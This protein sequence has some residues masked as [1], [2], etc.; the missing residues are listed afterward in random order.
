MIFQAVSSTLGRNLVETLKNV[1]LNK[2][3]IVVTWL[4][5]NKA[6]DSVRHNLIHFSLSWY[7]VPE[8]FANLIFQYYESLFTSEWSTG[9]FPFNIGVFQGCVIS[10]TLFIV[11]FQILIDY[12]DQLGRRP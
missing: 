8:W 9:L 7:H 12:I 1:N 4:D 11:G 3:Q 10:P 5:L 2:R 6:Y